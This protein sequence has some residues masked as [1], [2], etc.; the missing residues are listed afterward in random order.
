VKRYNLS[1]KQAAE[2]IGVSP[3]TM[4]RI[5]QR[6]EIEHLKHEGQTAR[7]TTAGGRLTQRRSNGF[8][9]L[10]EEDVAA[11]IAARVVPAKS[12]VAPVRAAPASR[13]DP[14]PMPAQRRFAR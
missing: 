14:L 7:R 5:I 2:M 11:W 8:V 10:A 12:P 4:Q 9:R 6:G 1:I 3:R 13:L